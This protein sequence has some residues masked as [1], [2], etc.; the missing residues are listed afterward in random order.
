VNQARR[1]RA[2]GSAV[3]ALRGAGGAVRASLEGGLP[4]AAEPR[5]PRI[6]ATMPDLAGLS[7][8]QASEKLAAAGLSCSH[9]LNG[10]KVIRQEPD[11][12]SPVTPATPC[13]VIF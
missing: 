9:D 8:R 7:L 4:A 10:P 3:P 2:P 13:A 1:D 11:P 5:S 12:G 6:A